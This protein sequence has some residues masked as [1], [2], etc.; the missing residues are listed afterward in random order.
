VREAKRKHIKILYD[1]DSTVSL[2]KYLKDDALIYENKIALTGITGHKVHT[3]EKIY[4]TF[5]ADRY[6]IK[7]AFY[8]IRSDTP[9]EYDGI[10][11]ID[12]LRKHS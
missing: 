5:N 9:I 3:L 2:I 6:T 1:S 12:F 8:V 7:H 4:A 11:G 10:L